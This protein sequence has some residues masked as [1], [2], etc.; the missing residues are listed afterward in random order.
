MYNA[1]AFKTSFGGLN[2]NSLIYLLI[3]NHVDDCDYEIPEIIRHS[4]HFADGSLIYTL[5]PKL[6]TSQYC[7]KLV[8]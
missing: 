2:T 8:D 7:L 1:N 4:P 6:A 5:R 3:T